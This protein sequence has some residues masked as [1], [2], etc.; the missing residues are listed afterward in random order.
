M[1]IKGVSGESVQFGV[2]ANIG[3]GTTIT[4]NGNWQR[5]TQ[6][7]TSGTLLIIGNYSAT[8]TDFEIWGAQLE[9]QSYA[10][11]YIPTQGSASTRI[12]ETCINSGSAQDFNSE[13]GVLYAEISALA[14]DGTY[15]YITMSDGTNSNRLVLGSTASAKVNYRIVSSLG[16]SINMVYNNI[17]VLSFNKIAASYKQNEFDLWVNGVKVLT[18]STGNVFSANVL[19]TLD[20]RDGNGTANFYG[21]TKNIQVFTKALSDEELQKLTTI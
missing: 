7:S 17:N 21:K 5:I 3:Q 14:D 9:E 1:Y 11:S 15:K 6:E 13:E 18:S 2:G 8:A 12:A 10:T 19:N 16:A 20:F 4:L